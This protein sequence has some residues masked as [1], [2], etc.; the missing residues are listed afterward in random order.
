MNSKQ[1]SI[2]FYIKDY[3]AR[4]WRVLP[5]S[6]GKKIPLLKSWTVNASADYNIVKQWWD[7]NPSANIGITTGRQSGFWALDIDMKNRS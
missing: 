5:I 7:Q 6:P 3:C 1:E 2:H 4:G